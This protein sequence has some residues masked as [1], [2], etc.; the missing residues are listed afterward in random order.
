MHE[1]EYREHYNCA[2]QIDP[3]Q[4]IQEYYKA[5]YVPGAEFFP[6]KKLLFFLQPLVDQLGGTT[7]GYRVRTKFAFFTSDA[8]VVAPPICYESIFGEFMYSFCPE[9]CRSDFY[10]DE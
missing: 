2:I 4:N 7:Y 10:Y 8:A 1:V 5:L 9:R 3:E 6:F